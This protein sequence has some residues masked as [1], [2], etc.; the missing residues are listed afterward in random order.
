MRSFLQLLGLVVL[1]FLCQDILARHDV[2]CEGGS[3]LIVV[4]QVKKFSEARPVCQELNGTLGVPFSEAENELVISLSSSFPEDDNIWLGKSL[5]GCSVVEGFLGLFDKDG[6]A[7]G[8][9][10]D[11]PSRFELEDTTSTDI[12][13]FETK[14]DRPWEEGEPND[15]RG[16]ENCVEYCAREKVA[17]HCVLGFEDQRKNGMTKTAPKKEDLSVVSHAS[18][19]GTLPRYK[20]V[21]TFMNHCH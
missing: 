19:R 18:M 12:N 5:A 15:R 20:K 21:T 2:S 11:D 8:S 4:D 13:F 9:S 1:P 3:Q 6:G 14:G 16:K 10:K 7:Q 17:E